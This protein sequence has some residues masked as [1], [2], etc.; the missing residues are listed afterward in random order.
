MLADIKIEIHHPSVPNLRTHNTLN[1]SVPIRPIVLSPSNK[2]LNSTQTTNYS[3]KPA[4][5]KEYL[6]RGLKSSSFKIPPTISPI[7]PTI[8]N[9]KYNTEPESD[10]S[11]IIRPIIKQD[12]RK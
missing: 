5:P 8:S 7:P 1:M 6:I 11:D 10:D 9:S 2:T 12:K 4:P 3:Q